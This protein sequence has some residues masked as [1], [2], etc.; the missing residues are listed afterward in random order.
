MRIGT[1]CMRYIQEPSITIIIRC[2]GSQIA[3]HWWNS[4]GTLK[5]H[6]CHVK[7]PLNYL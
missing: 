4:A 7:A 5:G 2:S 1:L 6:K 3:L